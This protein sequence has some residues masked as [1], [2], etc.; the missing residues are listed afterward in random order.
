LL[1]AGFPTAANNK[2]ICQGIAFPNAEVESIDTFYGELK[3]KGR[4]DLVRKFEW[5]NE[6]KGIIL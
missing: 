2:T 4:E 1:L 5:L 3:M 6:L